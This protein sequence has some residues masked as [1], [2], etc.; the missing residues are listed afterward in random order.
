MTEM[1]PGRAL[2]ESLKARG[3]RHVLGI[4]GST[5]LDVLD[6]LDDDRSVEY[7]NVR[8]AMPDKP[9]LDTLPPGLRQSGGPAGRVGG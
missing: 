1:S 3:V 5:F 7:V 9:P 8:Y 2:V 6:A 4:V